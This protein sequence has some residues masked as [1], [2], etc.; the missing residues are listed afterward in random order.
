[1]KII[2]YTILI[3]G[4][5]KLIFRDVGVGVGVSLWKT[6]LLS[7]IFASWKFLPTDLVTFQQLI[8]LRIISD[9]LSIIQSCFTYDLGVIDYTNKLLKI[10][11]AFSTTSIC[12]LLFTRV[13]ILIPLT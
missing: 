13:S 5:G 4:N 11:S 10:V 7:E 3:L 9:A 12:E 1:M 8:I 2:K 6:I